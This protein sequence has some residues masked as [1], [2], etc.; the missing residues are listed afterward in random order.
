ML[1]TT[2][3]DPC[4]ETR[5]GEIWKDPLNGDFYFFLKN[6][7][8]EFREWYPQFSNRL[9]RFNPIDVFRLHHKGASWDWMTGKVLGGEGYM[10]TDTT[11]THK[12]ILELDQEL[13]N[14]GITQDYLFPDRETKEGKEI[15]AVV[16]E[17]KEEF[18]A[19]W[20]HYWGNVRF[21]ENMNWTKY[22]THEGKCSGGFY[23][24]DE[25]GNS[26]RPYYDYESGHGWQ[27]IKPEV[28]MK[29]GRSESYYFDKYGNVCLLNSQIL[30]GRFFLEAENGYWIN[31]IRRRVDNLNVK[32]FWIR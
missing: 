29:P 10:H 4:K 6:P 2:L 19:E 26:F 24:F 30:G 21:G 15:E 31:T 1:R 18:K 20:M 12:D 14:R 9:M 23:L 27:L 8:Y 13:S 16:N 5:G 32:D 28:S 3:L 17:I 25:Q 11:L 22:F 7:F